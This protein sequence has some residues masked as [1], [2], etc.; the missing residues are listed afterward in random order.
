MDIQATNTANAVDSFV[1]KLTDEILNPIALVLFG[2]A[3]IYFFGGIIKFIQNAD[4]PTEREVGKQ[5]MVWG[6]VGM[7]VMFGVYGLLWF[8]R[9][10]L[11]I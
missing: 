6:V 9:T 1:T 5:S 4:N 3:F 10:S 2:L 11:G 7:F 8:L